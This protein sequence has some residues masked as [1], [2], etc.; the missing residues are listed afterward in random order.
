MAGS[1][2]NG[3]LLLSSSGLMGPWGQAEY[4]RMDL[5]WEVPVEI[6]RF[7][8]SSLGGSFL[9]GSGSG[10]LSCL[11]WTEWDMEE[12][13]EAYMEETA[14]VEG[15]LDGASFFCWGFSDD[16]SSVRGASGELVASSSPSKAPNRASRSSA[17]VVGRWSGLYKREYKVTAAVFETMDDSREI[18]CETRERRRRES[19]EAMSEEMARE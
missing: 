4:L 7:S 2:E 10:R 14:L 11:M 5:S 3:G 18:R 13:T 15:S 16:V 19:D 6:S 17:M 8:S 9:V 1:E 12:K